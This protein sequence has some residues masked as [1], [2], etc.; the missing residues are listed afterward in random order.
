V[1]NP[2]RFRQ[3]LACLLLGTPR[4]A[5]PASAAI[6]FSDRFN[7]PDGLITN[8]FAFWNPNDARAVKSPDW[9]MGSGSFFIQKKAAWSGVPDD[10]SK[11]SAS[12][13]ARSTN[14]TNSAVFRLHTKRF[15][16][17]NVKISFRLYN[18]GLVATT[19]TP[20][21]DWDGLHIF[22]RYQ[23]EYELY[24]AS[25]NRRDQ[26]AVIK[27]KCPGGPDNGGT[28]YPLTGSVPH[29]WS[30]E[31][32]QQVEATVVTNADHT[33]TIALYDDNGLVVQGTDTNI[34]K[35]P[36][37][38]TPGAVGIR[39]DN[40]N[41]KIGDFVVTD[42]STSTLRAPHAAAAPGADHTRDGIGSP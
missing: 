42:L 39:G 25:I 38:T 2:N 15:D 34:G 29:P 3:F 16:F 12:P 27:K 21:V 20:A 40:N 35:C 31:T 14:C 41:F 30:P 1:K 24:A 6:L 9:D 37:I 19:S 17:N 10:C 11:G 26:S 4:P 32:W 13:N 33:V 28:Y 22:L 8:E 18:K 36:A 5:F 23:T 7:R